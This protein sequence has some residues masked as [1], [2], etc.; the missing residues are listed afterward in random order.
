MGCGGNIDEKNAGKTSADL[1]QR[2][3]CTALWQTTKYVCFVH[4]APIPTA[5]KTFI[6]AE[7]DLIR[8]RSSKLQN[9]KTSKLQNF[10][11]SKLQNFKTSK[12]QNFETSKLLR[13]HRLSR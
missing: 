11:T 12:L 5:E 8:H 4:P 7:R 6:L 2:Y 1:S 3:C 10:K 13:S 9:F